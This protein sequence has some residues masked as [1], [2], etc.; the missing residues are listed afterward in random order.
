MSVQL[1]EFKSRQRATWDAGDYATLSERIADVGELVASRAEIGPGMAVLD[2]ACGAG[3]AAIPAARAG[4]QVTGL[5]LAPSLL[6]KA[7]AKAQKEG[8]EIEWVEGDAEAL[9]FEDGSFERVLSTFGHMFAPRHRQVA[10]EMIRVCR[11]GGAIVTATWTAEGVFG[12]MSAAAAGY[13]P[14]PPDYASPPV[15]WGSEEYSRDTFGSVATGIEFERHINWQE[16]DSV[17]SFADLFM[18][19]FPVM[20]AARAALGERF[21]ELREKIVDVWREANEADDGSLRLPQEY[22]LSVV[23]L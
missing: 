10:D 22:L 1:D 21:D 15:L 14:A 20:V 17:E 19:K 13:M 12:A 8:L 4:G 18:D 7:Q 16:A 5:D 3:N 11:T 2:V 9:P 23:R 6:E